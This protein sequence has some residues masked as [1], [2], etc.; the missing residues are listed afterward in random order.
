MKAKHFKIEELVYPGLVERG[1]DFAWQFLRPEA[2]VALDKIREKFGPCTVNNY[3]WGG[4]RVAS[5]LRPLVGG[6]GAV[7]SL[8]RFGA[9]FDVVPQKVTPIEVY[10]YILKN[11][12]EFPE[13]RRLEDAYMTKTWLHF[14]V[15]N[16]QSDQIVTF[17]KG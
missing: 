7:M 16:T 1:E 14:D 15:A 4:P 13:I 9:A 3:L 2:I 17:K 6:V 5:G 10:E 12:G 8:H 11:Q